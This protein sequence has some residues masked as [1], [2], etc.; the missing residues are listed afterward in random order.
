MERFDIYDENRNL[1]GRTKGRGEKLEEGEFRLVVHVVIFNSKGE[2]LIQ[3]RQPF[4]KSWPN[5]WDLSVGGCAISGETSKQTAQRELFE[6]LGIDLDFSK[7]RPKVTFNF[8]EAFNDV[9]IIEKDIDL[10][11]LNLQYEEVQTAKW[12]TEEEVLSLIEEGAFI[13]YSESYLSLLFYMHKY[14]GTRRLRKYSDKMA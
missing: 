5:F 12:A 7:L 9:F 11:D 6:E 1:T 10:N 2:M 14:N 4:K 13:P 8:D 3:Q